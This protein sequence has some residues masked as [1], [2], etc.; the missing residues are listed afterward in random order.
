M[1]FLGK[2]RKH[3]Y[4]FDSAI[5]QDD[6]VEFMK[7]WY[8]FEKNKDNGQKINY[9]KSNITKLCPFSVG[10]RI[11]RRAERLRVKA[12][13]PIAVYSYS[14]K[15]KAKYISDKD[16]KSVLQLVAKEVYNLTLPEDIKRF[17][18]HFIRVGACVLLHSSG[19][20]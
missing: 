7:F 11:T 16:I 12:H 1:V 18:S 6:E 17:S 13:T 4:A 19:K 2:N 10:L 15:K 8:I 14:S 5:V 9:S 20:D 3:F